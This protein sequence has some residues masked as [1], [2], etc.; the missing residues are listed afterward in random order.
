MVFHSFTSVFS[1]E[2]AKKN[3]KQF[4]PQASE[5][6]IKMLS[7]SANG[8]AIGCRMYKLILQFYPF[9]SYHKPTHTL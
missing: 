6:G 7:K 8:Y 4:V 3:L 2:D 1:S 9:L 5:N